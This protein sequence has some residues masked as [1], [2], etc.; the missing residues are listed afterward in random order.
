MR[1]T[2]FAMAIGPAVEVESPIDAQGSSRPQFDRK[3]VL[4]RGF[5][6]K[7]GCRGTFRPTDG[8]GRFTLES[9]GNF[10]KFEDAVAGMYHCGNV[11]VILGAQTLGRKTVRR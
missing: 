5:L 7:N 6:E 2:Q 3:Q 8:G 1:A 4:F 9:R 10:G 11:L